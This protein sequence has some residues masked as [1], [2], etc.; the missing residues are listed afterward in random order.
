MRSK[1]SLSKASLQGKALSRG[2]LFGR[3]FG[4]LPGP[5]TRREGTGPSTFTGLL[6][7]GWEVSSPSGGNFREVSSPI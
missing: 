3:L 6:Y 1:I 7:W 5:T 2:G 4:S